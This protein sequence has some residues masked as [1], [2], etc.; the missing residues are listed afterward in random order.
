[1]KKN[2]L[3]ILSAIFFM[4]MIVALVGGISSPWSRL[5]GVFAQQ[6]PFS[7]QYYT[8]QF[9]VNPAF[10]GTGENINAYLTHRSQWTGLA[11]APQTSYVTVDGP[12]QQK[13][14]G[15]GMKCF[16]D[17]TDI[18]SR[19]GAFASY[20][21]KL[22]INDS[23]HIYFGVS[24]GA[25][26]NK[27]DFSKAIIKDNNDPFL[28]SQSKSRT[29]FS[30]DLGVAYV[31]KRL[32]VGF[33]VPQI[34]GNNV[35]YPILND[36]SSYYNFS[37]HYQGTVK[38]V[39]DVSKEKG[40][41]AYP[42]LMF[43]A[44]K[45]APFQYDINGV[46]DWKKIGWVGLTYHSTYAFAF[47]GGVRYKNFIVGYAYDLGV[48]KIRSYIG[49]TSEFLL[50]YTFGERKKETKEFEK[51][52]SAHDSLLFAKT[53]DTIQRAIAAQMKAMADSN[54]AQIAKLKEELAK[55]KPKVESSDIVASGVD[56]PAS[57]A[58]I[59]SR[60]VD[61]YGD[62]IADAEMD[63]VDK[64]ANKVVAHLKTAADG[65]Y[66]VV[67]P[68]GKS[69]DIVFNKPG[70]LFK[71]ITADIPDVAGYKTNLNDVTISKLEAGKKVVLN[72]ILFDLNRATIKPESF[73]ELDRTVK[74]IN[75]IPS[76]EMEVSGHT[77][78]IGA[79]AVN[80]ELSEQ[81]AKAVMDYL[82]A[83]GC[84]KNRLSYK[85]YGPS[86]PIASNGTDEG[87]KTNRRTEFKV[88]KVD[89]QYTIVSGKE[90]EKVVSQNNGSDVAVTNPQHEALMAQLKTKSDA[91]QKEIELLKSELAKVKSETKSSSKNN[92]SISEMAVLKAKSDSNQV[93]IERLKSELAKSKISETKTSE[94]KSSANDALVAQLKA[95][96]DSN[97]VQI[98][99][100]KSELAKSKISETKT[101]ETKSSANDALVAQLKA[102]SDSNQVQIE[103]LKSELAKNKISETKSVETKVAANDAL[104]AQLKA[105]SD[106][107]Q[108]QIERLKSELAKTK[109]AE[110]KTSE[111][112][113]SANDALV[114]Q[115]KTKSDSSQLQL[116]QLK[117]ELTKV[118]LAA[119]T[120]A[121]N[122][123][124][125]NS[126]AQL[127]TKSDSNKFEI[128]QLKA[129]LAKAKIAETKA[130]TKIAGKDSA[131]VALKAKSDN[132]QVQIELLKS[133]LSKLKTAETKTSS[134][135]AN[136]AAMAQLK[137][138]ADSNKMELERLKSELA[139]SKI[140]E[141]KAPST[142]AN[143]AAMA[144]LKA[145]S[146]SNKVELDRLKAELAKSKIAEAKTPVSTVNDAAV[147][148]LKTKSDSNKMEIDLLK[149][150][151]AKSKIAEAKVPVASTNDAAMAQLKAKSDSNK[152]E[153]DRLK[154]ELAKSKIAEAKTPTSTV[155]DVAVA[156]LKTKS[157]SNKMEIDLLKAELAKSKIAD[158]KAPVTSTNDAA[159]A[160][161]KAKSDSNKV[162]IDRLKAEL[163]KTR[164]TSGDGVEK[165]Q[166]AQL[167]IK[168][169]TSQQ[170]IEQLKWELTKVKLATMSNSASTESAASIAQLKAKSDS[171]KVEIERLKAELGKAK[172]T[173]TKVAATSTNDAVVAQ[174]KA[175]S[176]KNQEQITALKAELE[177]AKST[178][179]KAP[180]NVAND[181]AVAQL[182]AQADKNQEQITALKAELEKAKT[183]TTKSSS[184]EN[185]ALVAQLK[186]K[187]DT[188]QSDIER[189]KSELEKLKA[190]NTG[191]SVASNPIKE[192]TTTTQTK[193][194]PTKEKVNVPTNTNTNTTVSSTPG[195]RTYKTES[196]NDDKG[197]SAAVG[198]YVV[199]GTFGS[200]ENAEKCKAAAV[201]K[202]HATTKIV[203]NQ[204]TKMYNVV[205]VR[206]NNKE[207]ADA[208]RGKYKGEYPDAWILKLE[209]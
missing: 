191:N 64:S 85:G 163:G 168:S 145:K 100:L 179:T 144:Q 55:A 73:V 122:A 22:K 2:K 23:S 36:N 62:P 102:K 141:T 14:T 155:N 140:A 1:M 117:W 119:M 12:L 207:D 112:K 150:E 138:V 37:R 109:I 160:Q 6:L 48:S 44:V 5:G 72:N 136:D 208:E 192:T 188:Y 52:E 28:Y 59:T 70:F 156:Q 67:V 185:D 3:L 35:K 61:D 126:I 173:E 10:T 32:T 65:T 182:K 133:E 80:Q 159:V 154:A 157:D 190:S 201:I 79:V 151:L 15:L 181:A 17:V 33:A 89:G 98:E 189:L 194:E 47:S 4:P 39:F 58:V 83:K 87:R 128:E 46:V 71:S 153:L 106:S 74:L 68:K 177:K 111:T 129:E 193:V 164:S 121:P 174:L 50:G 45:G 27:L 26:G 38:Y 60:L 134:T 127:K 43:R 115:L 107:N 51:E 148:Q 114:A 120:N 209:Q 75:D 66:R 199:V 54:Q 170:Q 195:V 200:K 57:A 149:A 96:S 7:S 176:D 34:L 196:F 8:D 116:E 18:I 167:K 82:V 180:T 99:R 40:I 104:V 49:T 103:R 93:Q 95:K 147:A 78:N 41:T 169:D 31:W 183:S 92:E 13:N 178:E 21:Y 184:S 132:N 130:S 105:K 125:T 63:V 198:F 172:S 142:S 203:Q 165:E 101:S 143:D 86:Q 53:N 69:Y 118:K 20:S 9:V 29:V 19:V 108:V 202:G 88:L 175:Q 161:L 16:T 81:R 162:E 24:A 206:T 124:N 171:N 146:D 84:D 77:D 25:L 187:S 110:S 90:G 205:V 94:T 91:N 113:S 197:K 131:V 158:A 76:L 56:D 135:S 204:I 137:A 186:S 42:L 97:Q 152:V 166:I 11:G 139:K 30:A 123:E